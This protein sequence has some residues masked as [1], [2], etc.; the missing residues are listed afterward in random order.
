[1]SAA[2]LDA[3][4]REQAAGIKAALTIVRAEQV[5][6]R[7][8]LSDTPNNQRANGADEAL[9]TVIDALLDA[10]GIP[11]ASGANARSVF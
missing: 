3:Q 8:I 2:E 6:A 7:R 1:M 5:K 11:A 4:M 9:G 10:L